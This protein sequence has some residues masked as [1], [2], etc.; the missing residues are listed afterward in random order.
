MEG[1]IVSP[2]LRGVGC[3]VLTTQAHLE[4]R[5]GEWRTYA[6]GVENIRGRGG[7]RELSPSGLGRDVSCRGLAV[8]LFREFL[9]LGELPWLWRDTGYLEPQLWE[10]GRGPKVKVFLSG[11]P[12][13]SADSDP[14]PP[15]WWSYLYPRMSLGPTVW[16]KRPEEEAAARYPTFYCPCFLLKEMGTWLLSACQE[17][18]WRPK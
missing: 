9:P 3:Y 16:L 8:S 14:W 17:A 4:E 1:E 10:H 6:G 18:V 12:A 13:V 2:R 11:G 15:S 7:E 5:S